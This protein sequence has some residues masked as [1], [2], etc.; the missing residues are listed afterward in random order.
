MTGKSFV[1]GKA[2][3]K[4]AVADPAVTVD[5][6]LGDPAKSQHEVLRQLVAGDLAGAAGAERL[7]TS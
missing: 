7:V 4:I 1:A 2:V 3:K 5:L 6:Q